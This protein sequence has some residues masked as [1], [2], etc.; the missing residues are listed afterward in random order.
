MVETRKKQWSGLPAL[1]DSGATAFSRLFGYLDWPWEALSSLET[2]LGMLLAEDPL[3]GHSTPADFAGSQI[4]GDLR[5]GS[6]VRIEAGVRIEGTVHIG[7]GCHIESGAYIRGPVWLAEGCEVRQG[8]YIRGNVIAG[9]GAV[10][11]HCSEFKQAILLEQAQAPHFNYVGDSILGIKAHIGA[12]VILSNLRL[13]K[14]PVRAALLAEHE[15][16]AEGSAMHRGKLAVQAG[17]RVNFI[18]TGLGKFGALVGDG[19]E[20]GCNCVLNP[21]SILGANSRAAPLSRIRGT[22]P[23]DSTIDS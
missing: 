15:G 16:H 3:A 5:L 23:E 9:A 13:D 4:K 2:Y 17:N 1:F 21:G 8:A 11:G 10:L 22:W 19:C 18:D 20:I 14:R 12:G 7:A 6:K